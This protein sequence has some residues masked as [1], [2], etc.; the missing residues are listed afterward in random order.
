MAAVA[1]L[2]VLAAPAAFASAEPVG[3]L[4]KGPVFQVNVLRDASLVI[5]APKRPANSG[6]VWRVARKFNPKVVRQAGEGEDRLNVQLRLK[7]VGVGTLIAVDRVPQRLALAKELGASHVLD[8]SGLSN[9]ASE[10]KKLTG[11]GADFSLDTTGVPAVTRQALDCLAPRGFCG[12]VGGAPAGSEMAVDVRDMMIHGKTLRGIVEGDA[13][14]DVFIPAM[15]EMQAR[16][17]FPFEKLVQMYPFEHVN[18]AIADSKSGK[19]VKPILKFL[20]D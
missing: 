2:A 16:G 17:R 19:T 6:L 15:I 8:A 20:H 14:P 13:N 11:H 18:E 10:V 4:P 12:F 1:V 5:R 3:P 7:A 9:V